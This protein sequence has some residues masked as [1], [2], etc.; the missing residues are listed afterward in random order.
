MG[1]RHPHC[2]L[3]PQ[4]LLAQPFWKALHL[5]HLKWKLHRKVNLISQRA[6]DWRWESGTRVDMDLFNESSLDFNHNSVLLEWLHLLASLLTVTTQKCQTSINIKWM[7]DLLSEGSTFSSEAIT[8]LT[9]KNKT[10]HFH[11]SERHF[12]ALL[13][14]TVG[15]KLW[16]ACTLT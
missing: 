7:H 9:F 15:K 5:A 14:K 10:V 1:W 12:I 16:R 8:T 6:A 13:V 4:H 11:D 3:N 2:R